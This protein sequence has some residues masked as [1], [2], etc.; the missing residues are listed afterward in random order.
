MDHRD[1]CRARTKALHEIELA[2]EAVRDAV[3]LIRGRLK[4][5]DVDGWDLADLKKE[6]RG[7][8]IQKRTWK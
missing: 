6:L 5:A 2:D 8:N 3:V 1:I 7:F 4:L